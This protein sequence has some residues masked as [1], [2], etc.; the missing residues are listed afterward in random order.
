VFLRK[1]DLTLSAEL[2]TPQAHAALQG[3]QHAAIPLAGVAAL[4][5]F[6][7]GDSVES[8]I[9][10]QQRDDLV[11]EKCIGLPRTLC[12]SLVFMTFWT[13]RQPTTRTAH[14]TF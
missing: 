9:R 10:L 13:E 3:A 14:S 8:G 4:Q 7:Q 11:L 1:V 6:E 2:G 12:T 5:F